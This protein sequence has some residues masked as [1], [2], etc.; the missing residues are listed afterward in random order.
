MTRRTLYAMAV[1]AAVAAMVICGGPGQANGEPTVSSLASCADVEVV[2]ARGTF[3]SPGVGKVGEPFIEAIRQRLPDRTVGTYPVNY[4]ASLQFDRAVEGI[5]DAANRL[6][7][8]A[9]RCPATDIV[10]GGYSQGAAVSA[11]LTSETVPAGYALTALP[12]DIAEKIT[13]VV[14][15]GKP[16]PRVLTL[17]QRDAPAIEISPAFDDRTIELCAPRDPVCESGGLDRVAHS[18]YAV[19]GMDDQ[20][21]EFVIGRLRNH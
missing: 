2:F 3:E 10:V 5:V 12:P 17:L 13:A 9:D 7:H 21:A 16:S 18:A 20:A 8:V 15:F 4:L 14:L 11:Y 6:R 1:G 19:N